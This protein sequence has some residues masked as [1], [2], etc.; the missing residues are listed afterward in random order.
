MRLRG[1]CKLPDEKGKLGLDLVGRMVLNVTK[2]NVESETR[3][4]KR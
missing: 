4:E 2:Y 1:L 3:Y